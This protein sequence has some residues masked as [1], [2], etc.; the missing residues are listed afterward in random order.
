MLLNDGNLEEGGQL[1]AHRTLAYHMA[2]R[3]R[4]V[5]IKHLQQAC[6]LAELVRRRVGRGP[7]RADVTRQWSSI[8]HMLA[9]LLRLDGKNRESFEALQGEKPGD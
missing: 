2:D 9:R 6:E 1:V 5:A 4:S 7:D 3:N 8:Y